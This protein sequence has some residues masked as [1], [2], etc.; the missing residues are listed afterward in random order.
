M[1]FRVKRPRRR[2]RL[3]VILSR[4]TQAEAA[5][6][7]IAEPSSFRILHLQ[8]QFVKSLSHSH[9]ELSAISISN[10][11]G[12][13]QGEHEFYVRSKRCPDVAEGS[14]HHVLTGQYLE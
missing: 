3:C 12:E 11:I 9:P 7:D 13:P 4:A 14:R 2:A 8:S 10:A 5:A 6:D 1:W